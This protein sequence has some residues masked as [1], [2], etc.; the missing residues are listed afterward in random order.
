MESKPQPFGIICIQA[1]CEITARAET[2]PEARKIIEKNLR[3]DIEILKFTVGSAG[4]V[5]IAVFP[6][7]FLTGWPL[8]ESAERFMQKSCC[9]IPGEETEQLSEQ[10]RAF[11]IYIAANLYEIDDEWPGCWFNCS[12]IINPEG[13][14]VSKYRRLHTLF[15]VSPYDLLEE[16]LKKYTI[17]DIFPV[18]E[19]PVGRIAAYPC[20]E[21]LL[22]EVARGFVFNGAEILL[23]CMGGGIPE[24]SLWDNMRI[25]RAAENTAYLAS[26]CSGLFLGAPYGTHVSEGG[27]TIFD[28]EGRALCRARGPGETTIGTTID[29]NALRHYRTNVV[30]GK[31]LTRL[32]PDLYQLIYNSITISVPN[33][34][35]NQPP[36]SQREIFQKARANL[37]KLYENG[38]LVK[39]S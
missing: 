2:A 38:F 37:D 19:T 35:V 9:Q 10:A 21:I 27:S 39:P 30:A 26:A 15:G 4:N 12:F 18:V 11:G 8:Q 5:K 28:Y 3:R 23:H 29:I 31:M 13:K 33:A 6:E 34:F 24:G 1:N 7:F 14:V 17:K 16:Y 25:V 22:P 36:Q 32:K 20:G